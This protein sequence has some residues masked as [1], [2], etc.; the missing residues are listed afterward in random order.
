MPPPPHPCRTMAWPSDDKEAARD[1]SASTLSLTCSLF[2][3]EQNLTLACALSTARR[4]RARRRLRPPETTPTPPRDAPCFPRPPRRRSRR[5]TSKFDD[6]VLVFSAS[7]CRR[8]GEIRR[9]PS[10][11]GLPIHGVT[12]RV[13]RGTSTTYPSSSYPSASTH[14]CK[15]AAVRPPAVRFDHARVALCLPLRLLALALRPPPP[16]TCYAHPRS[17]VAPP[18]PG[19]RRPN[20]PSVAADARPVR[21]AVPRPAPAQRP[22]GSG[23]CPAW[24]PAWA[25]H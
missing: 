12:L 14:P 17:R 6:A 8:R 20:S 2:L 9:R 7:G 21:P 23:G 13:S 25:G 16:G 22:A 11:P 5:G 10:S 15:A 1:T 4:R 18:K 19:R 24:H 3:S